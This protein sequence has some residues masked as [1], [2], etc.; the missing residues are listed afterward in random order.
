VPAGKLA[1]LGAP[2]RSSLTTEGTEGAAPI[3]RAFAVTG[4][5]LAG[6]DATNLGDLS[7]PPP[8]TEDFVP[9]GSVPKNKSRV[10]EALLAIAHRIAESVRLG[11]TPVVFGGDATVLLGLLAGIHD[12]GAP[13]TRLGLLSWDGQARFRTTEEYPRGDLSAMVLSLAVGRGDVS[14]TH[15]AR[16]RFPLLQE[17]EV[18]L[19]G[20]RDAAPEEATALVES[21]IALL[22]PDRLPGAD[23]EAHFTE[24]LGRL[25]R[26][27]QDVVV[28]LDV[29]VLD[30]AQYPV[31][32]GV[33]APGGLSLQRLKTLAG[34]L[35]RWHADGTV[36]IAGV[37]ITGVDARKDPGGVRMHELA[38]FA[39]RLFGRRGDS[40]G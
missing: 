6:L 21:R 25:V 23:G 13:A 24:A 12:G 4:A 8:G 30:P 38:D 7:L 11:S 10:R 14:L 31:A 5:D 32:V 40:A 36:R 29:S 37:A 3:L 18:V 2:L 16:E 34:E 15:L 1:L 20:V 26:R 19:A 22:P 27:T 35:S 39:L 9:G 28:E 33:P 17:T